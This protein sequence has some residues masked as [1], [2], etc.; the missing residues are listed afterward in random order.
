MQHVA[1]PVVLSDG[2]ITIRPYRAQDIERHHAAVCASVDDVAPWLDWCHEGYTRAESQM[3]IASRPEAWAQQTAYSFA[4]VDA[5]DGAFLGGCGLN[6]VNPAHGLANMGYWVRSDRTKQGIATRAARLIARFGFETLALH[7]IE[8]L[9]Q[10]NNR[11]SRRVA[12]RLGAVYE[13]R[14]RHRIVSHGS[15]CDALLYSLLPSDRP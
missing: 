8:I 2:Q 9:M 15:P 13:G 5:L 6:Q 11:G 7:R 4:V 3:W 12:E 10:P 14:C 1:P